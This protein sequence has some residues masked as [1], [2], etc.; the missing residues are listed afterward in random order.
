MK[1]PGAK[2]VMIPDIKEVFRRSGLDTFIDVF[3]GSGVVSLNIKAEKN[4]YND[5]DGELV[6]LF[7]MIQKR[8][9]YIYNELK[10]STIQGGFLRENYR[11]KKY[12]DGGGAGKRKSNYTPEGTRNHAEF[13]YGKHKSLEERAF[14]TLLR[15]T[16]SFG[17]MGETYNTS[18]KSTYRYAIKTLDQFESIEEA[19]SGWIIENLDFRDLLKKYDGRGAFFYIDPPFYE[20]KWY[21][22]NFEDEDYGDLKEILGNLKGKYLMN[23]NTEDVEL[24]DIF[25]EPDFI[26]SYE[27]RNQNAASNKRP[28]RLKSFYTNV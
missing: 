6:N 2:N 8:P 11:K 21:N 1:Y 27:N 5:L 24:A 19:V 10:R 25:D 20:K 3:G 17:G 4:I 18:E 16:L 26:K 23:L 15:F 13:D 9:S 22:C 7:R 12:I 28:P 14:N